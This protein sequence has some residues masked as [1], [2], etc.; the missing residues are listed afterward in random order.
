MLGTVFAEYDELEPRMLP[1]FPQLQPNQCAILPDG[2]EKAVI[3]CCKGFMDD[4]LPWDQYFPKTLEYYDQSFQC[5]IY[6]DE[7]DVP[8]DSV[9]SDH[10][11]FCEA[12]FEFVEDD[13]AC[14]GTRKRFLFR[15]TDSNEN[16]GHVAFLTS[17]LWKHA[18]VDDEDRWRC[19]VCGGNS[20]DCACTYGGNNT[21]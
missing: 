9:A 12:T 15:Y 2:E 4:N 7:I 6:S 11:T 5:N 3:A 17:D 1:K 8:A 13:L 21:L 10:L 16:S 20:L 19:V 14:T 18:V